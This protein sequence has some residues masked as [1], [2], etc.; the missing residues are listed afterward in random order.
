MWRKMLLKAEANVEKQIARTTDRDVRLSLAGKMA[1]DF[2]YCR[3]CQPVTVHTAHRSPPCAY[4]KA[5][6]N[7]NGLGDNGQQQHRHHHHHHQRYS[8][9]LR[10]H[11]VCQ[12]V[13]LRFA[14]FYLD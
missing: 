8:Q 4:K 2:W 3:C 6:M 13:K 14:I 7:T 12:V 11:S 9:W 5:T 1:K 10:I